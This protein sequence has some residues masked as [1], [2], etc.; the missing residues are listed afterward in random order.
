MYNKIYGN[1]GENHAKKF[2]KKS[3]YKVLITNYTKKFGEA[4][5]IALEKKA[6]R[7]KREEFKTMPK[8]I[9][10]EDVVVFI[11]VK[12]RKNEDYGKPSEAVNKQKQQKYM[13]IAR[14][15][16]MLNQKFQ[17]KSYR[18]DIIEVTGESV[19]GHIINA[20]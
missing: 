6:A 18:F 20:F 10:N 4:D 8:E 3:G 19:A 11:E 14:T 5:I 15:F 9:Q 1:Y 7:K 13:S 16:F 17:G 12:T 2:L